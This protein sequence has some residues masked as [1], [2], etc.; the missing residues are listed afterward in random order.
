MRYRGINADQISPDLFA[1]PDIREALEILNES[2]FSKEELEQYDANYDAI[3]KQQSTAPNDN[4][5]NELEK[6]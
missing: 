1:H 2:N 5:A 3:V 4:A 6:E